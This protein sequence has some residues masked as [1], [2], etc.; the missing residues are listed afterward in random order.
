MNWKSIH[1]RF[2]VAMSASG[3]SGNMWDRRNGKLGVFDYLNGLKM[4]PILGFHDCVRQVWEYSESGYEGIKEIGENYWIQISHDPWLPWLAYG[5]SGDM[6]NPEFK[7][8]GNPGNQMN[9]R[10]SD[11]IL[12]CVFLVEDG[13]MY[14]SNPA[15]KARRGVFCCIIVGKKHKGIREMK[16]VREVRRINKN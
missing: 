14:W 12:S 7:K 5:K 9:S 6:Q 13:R 8:S 4:I 2:L 15:R 3:K 16:K 10:R 11:M 1:S